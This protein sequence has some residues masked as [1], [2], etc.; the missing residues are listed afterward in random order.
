MEDQIADFRYQIRSNHV[1]QRVWPESL[2]RSRRKVVKDRFFKRSSPESVSCL[3]QGMS[4]LLQQSTAKQDCT[5]KIKR[6]TR[7]AKKK[8]NKLKI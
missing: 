1:G 4:E 5:V 8:R 7:T 6:T 3:T 2:L